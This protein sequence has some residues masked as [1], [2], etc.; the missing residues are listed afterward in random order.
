M[1]NTS[2]AQKLPRCGSS[3][4]CVQGR[5]HVVPTAE[6]ISPGHTHFVGDSGV[7]EYQQPGS[8]AAEY[9]I[10]E[11]AQLSAVNL[12]TCCPAADYVL[13]RLE[14]WDDV[15]G[16]KLMSMPSAPESGGSQQLSCS[17][18]QRWATHNRRRF[19]AN[20]RIANTDPSKSSWPVQAARCSYSIL[21]EGESCT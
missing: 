9:D 19:D 17:L 10:T 11:S 13:L 3:F 8:L 21:S 20:R 12:G 15:S 4:S 16:E 2:R 6:S 5:C 14:L 18:R 7:P 1:D